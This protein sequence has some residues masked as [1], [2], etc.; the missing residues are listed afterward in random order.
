VLGRLIHQSGQSCG[1][2]ICVD[3]IL[4]SHDPAPPALAP[5]LLLRQP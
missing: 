3:Y 4:Y 1:E 2:L 5:E